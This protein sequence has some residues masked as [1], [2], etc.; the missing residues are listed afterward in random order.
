M[1]SQRNI[2][3]YFRGQIDRKRQAHYNSANFHSFKLAFDILRAFKMDASRI[4]ILL[5]EDHPADIEL[6]RRALQK[7]GLKNPLHLAKD[8]E[9]ASRLLKTGSIPIGVVVLDI[10]LPKMDGMSVLKLAKSLDPETVVIMLTG[11]ASMRTAV[12]SLRR[13]GAF[14]YLEKS[15]DDLPQLV[16]AIHLAIKKRALSL[17]TLWPFEV[18]GKTHLIEMNRVKKKF[19]LSNRE[20]DV[21]KCICRGDTNKEIAEGLFISELTVKTHLKTIYAKTG[22]HNRT[23]LSATI[24]SNAMSR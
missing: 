3:Y 1:N 18:G 20:I 14:D 5:V 22:V 15:K 6:I 7:D 12:E 8:G 17:Q 11:H 21:V 13:E 23:S 4:P 16:E 9:E 19:G 10:H 24:L 2:H